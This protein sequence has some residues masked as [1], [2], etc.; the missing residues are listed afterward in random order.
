MLNRY[1]IF[2]HD[3]SELHHRERPKFPTTTEVIETVYPV[4]FVPF[5][6]SEAIAGR[7]YLDNHI[8]LPNNPQNFADAIGCLDNAQWKTAIIQELQHLG[9]KSRLNSISESPCT[10]TATIIHGPLSAI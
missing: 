5:P 6:V 3:N 4:G 10:R 1:C 2:Y 9:A 7:Q 8:L